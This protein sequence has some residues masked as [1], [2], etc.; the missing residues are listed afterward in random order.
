MS[1]QDARG[2]E[3]HE[4]AE[5]DCP[6]ERVKRPGSNDRRISGPAEAAQRGGD[7]FAG[8]RRLLG[9]GAGQQVELAA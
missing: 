9:D 6:I 1:A 8:G 3:E 5:P 4:T 7:G 2:P